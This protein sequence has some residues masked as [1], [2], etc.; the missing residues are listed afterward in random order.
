[1]LP[2]QT[3][4]EVSEEQLMSA[5]QSGET[6]IPALPCGSLAATLPFYQTLG[7][8]V[9]Y[10]Q[11]SPNPYAV[12]CRGGIE[13]HF[14]GLKGLQ[15]E[16]AFST[17]IVLVPDVE[18]L[19]QTFAAALRQAYRKLPVAGFPRIT[20]MK[21]GQTRFTVVDPAGNSVIYI[22]RDA[23]SPR[24]E[25]KSGGQSQSGLAKAI[26]TA[27]TLRDSSGDDAK[28]AK[29]L[30]VAL[31]RYDPAPAVDRARALAARA[32]LA[33]ALGDWP[34]ARALRDEL[35]QVPLAEEDRQRLGFELNAA[36]ELERWLTPAGSEAGDL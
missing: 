15:P 18:R 6:M 33:V 32:E 31:A 9:T 21:P 3:H 24:G 2:H 26:E 12:V 11:K 8:E 30:D 28:A 35:Q 17:C 16:E 1:V 34:R 19:H 4:R 27:A 7:F 22:R 10:Q 13:L 20:R 23:H 29:V 36:D 5:N 25:R 14:F